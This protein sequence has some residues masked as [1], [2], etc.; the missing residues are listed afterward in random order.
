MKDDTKNQDA[1]MPLAVDLDG[2]IIRTDLLLET[3]NIFILKNPIHIFKVLIWLFKGRTILKEKLAVFSEINASLLPYNKSIVSWLKEQHFLGREIILI[4]ASTDLLALSVGGYLGIFK[5]IFGSSQKINLKGIKKK[6]LLIEK[7][8]VGGFD[9]VGNERAD[10]PIWEVC[11]TAYVVNPSPRFIF[12]LKKIKPDIEVLKDNRPFIGKSIT[13]VLRPHQWIKN[14]LI[15]IPLFAAQEYGNPINLFQTMIAFIVFCLTASSAYVLNDLIDLKND[16]YHC[17]KKNRPFASGDLSILM[18][19]VLWPILLIFGLAIS[20]NFLPKS[21]IY[22]QLCY[23]FLTLLYSF[24][25][26]KLV[27]IDVLALAIL[28][29]LR[30]IAGIAATGVPLSFWLLTFSI[31]IFL[32]LAFIKRFSEIKSAHDIG[33][34]KAIKGR[35]YLTDDLEVVSSMGVS[36]GFISVLVLALYIQDVHT[37]SLYKSPEVIWLVCPMLLMWVSRIWLISHRGE[38]HDDPVVFALKDRFS[39]LFAATIVSVVLMAK[40]CKF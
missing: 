34:D 7:Y 13:K 36:A 26:K 9:Y 14:I 4:T 15:F 21:F 12:E 20:V 19:W 40:Y 6:E 24:Y 2:T 38:M 33:S 22:I 28:Y 29:T 31:F 32:S 39:Q 30:I 27:I 17:S 37:A 5:K 3:A 18:G 11:N 8:G 35:G 16:R 23:L 25:I 1:F 10:I